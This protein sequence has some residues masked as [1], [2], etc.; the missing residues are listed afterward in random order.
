M[1]VKWSAPES[2]KYGFFTSKSDVWS[3]GV[4]LWEL[5]SRGETPYCSMT[6]SEAMEKIL[7]GNINENHINKHYSKGIAYLVLLA[8]QKNYIN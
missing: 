3:F 7:Q 4:C 5:F 6:N 2:L 1:P 8:V